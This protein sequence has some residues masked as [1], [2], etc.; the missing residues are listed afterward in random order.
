MFF[1]GLSSHAEDGDFMMSIGS[2]FTSELPNIA[3]ISE[4]CDSDESPSD[5]GE[6]EDW[7]DAMEDDL[8][9]YMASPVASSA[10][11]VTP[12]HLSKLWRISH[13]EAR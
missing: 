3:V 4:E 12:E 1:D 11:G 10:S 13:E 2:T 6:E 9:D 7:F 8:N 5:S